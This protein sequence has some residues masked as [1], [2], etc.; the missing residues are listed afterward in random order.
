MST[1]NSS[2]EAADRY[3]IWGDVYAVYRAL[4]DEPMTPSHRVYFQNLRGKPFVRPS[5]LIKVVAERNRS[6]NIAT[7]W[8]DIDMMIQFYADTEWD[9]MGVG[10]RVVELFSGFPEKLLPKWDFSGSVPEKIS[11]SGIDQYGRR[12]PSQ[13]GI[14][15]SPD[16]VRSEVDDTEDGRWQATVEF[17]MVSPRRAKLDLSP[18]LTSASYA[19]INYH[20]NLP[21]RVSMSMTA[22][23]TATVT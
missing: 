15:V 20:A 9:A 7:R 4:I 17:T 21:Q 14:R 18:Y 23:Q 11:I 2:A 8:A 19:V 13:M 12:V 16:S 5:F 1:I 22:S 10:S 6:R 3:E